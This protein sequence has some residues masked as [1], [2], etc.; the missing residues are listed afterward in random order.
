M[1]L[2]HILIGPRGN[3]RLEFAVFAADSVTALEQNV[4]LAE[5]GERV[6]IVHVGRPA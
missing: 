2:F 6:E 1:Y 5:P 3:P 4:C